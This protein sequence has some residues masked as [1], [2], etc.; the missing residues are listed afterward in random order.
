MSQVDSFDVNYLEFKEL[1]RQPGL[2]YLLI[3][4]RGCPPCEEMLKQFNWLATSEHSKYRDNFRF[5]R[6]DIYK[7][8]QLIGDIVDTDARPWTFVF[9]DGKVVYQMRGMPVELS[10]DGFIERAFQAAQA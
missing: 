4:S 7:N 9:K 2:L 10:M 5:A 8:P 3:Y 1:Q 6:I